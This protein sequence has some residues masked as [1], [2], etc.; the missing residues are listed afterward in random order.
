M[1]SKGQRFM[2]ELLVSSLMT[3]GGLESSLEDA[4]RAETQVDTLRKF[5]CCISKMLVKQDVVR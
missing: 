2:T 5:I 3:D 4:L 1:L